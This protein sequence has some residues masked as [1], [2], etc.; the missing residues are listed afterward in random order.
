MSNHNRWGVARKKHVTSMLAAFGMLA[1]GGLAE[2]QSS[3]NPFMIPQVEEEG[4]AVEEPSVSYRGETD[5][6]PQVVL[7]E[8]YADDIL[9]RISMGSLLV[10]VVDSSTR[11]YWE[12]NIGCYF[13]ASRTKFAPSLC[14]DHIKA[15]VYVHQDGAIEFPRQTFGRPS[16]N[17][18]NEEA[19]AASADILADSQH[20]V[21]AQLACTAAYE[22]MDKLSSEYPGR[23]IEFTSVKEAQQEG[24][25]RVDST[26]C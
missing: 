16:E 26:E 7:H 2:A 8:R 15:S 17:P 25:S 18:S 14:V 24:Y 13:K 9:Q 20:D 10:G 6:L 1:L 11:L 22:A 12:P 19:A 5:L 3:R 4:E 21:Y 23:I